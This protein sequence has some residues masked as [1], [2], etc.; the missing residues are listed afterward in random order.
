MN[1]DAS[2]VEQPSGERGGVVVTVGAHLIDVKRGLGRYILKG[3]SP[4]V[5]T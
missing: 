2:R 1:R 3:V 5:A 4:P